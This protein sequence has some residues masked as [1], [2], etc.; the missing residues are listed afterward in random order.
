MTPE[1]KV[2]LDKLSKEMDGSI[3]FLEVTLTKIRAGKASPQMLQGV[4]VDYYGT[5]T[6]IEQIGTI[7]T[8]DAKQITIQPWDRNILKD[9]EKALLAANLGFTP[10]NT[11]EI[12]RI[13]LPP[14]TAERRNEL[15]KK[16]KIEAENAKVALRN[17]R[18]DAMDDAK[19]LEKS[20]LSEDERKAL[21]KDIQ[22]T[23]NKYI[24]KVDAILKEK[25][26]DIM[27]V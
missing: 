20:G 15:V 9:I 23:L 17:L 22:D 25:E 26:K 6:P 5:P 19:K 12:I 24:D 4:V 21:E 8:P 27:T 1:T 18:R 2:T 7:A 11:G 16:A 14:V 3:H 13:I 10:S